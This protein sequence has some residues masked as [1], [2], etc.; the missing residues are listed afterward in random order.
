MQYDGNT[1]SNDGR[2]GDV[3]GMKVILRVGYS[4]RTEGNVMQ[5][6]GNTKSNDGR[7]GAVL[8]MEIK[9]SRFFMQN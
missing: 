1:K 6:D 5:Y 8:G 4:S 7:I 9:L 3:S 2:I